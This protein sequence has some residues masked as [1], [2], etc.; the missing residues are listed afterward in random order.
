MKVEYLK[1][2]LSPHLSPSS[3]QQSIFPEK[4]SSPANTNSFIPRPPNLALPLPLLQDAIHTLHIRL[5]LLLLCLSLSGSHRGS[6]SSLL[7]RDEGFSCAPV[8]VGGYVFGCNGECCGWTAEHLCLG[9]ETKGYIL[10]G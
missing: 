5:L 9:I 7:R 10:W 2:N 3:R 4:S 1:N 8:F 6:P